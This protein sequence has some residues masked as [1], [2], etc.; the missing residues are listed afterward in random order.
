MSV[1]RSYG[2]IMP[3]QELAGWALAMK[4]MKEGAA[5]NIT[6]LVGGDHEEDMRKM[7]IIVEGGAGV[8][9]YEDW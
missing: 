4:E 1:G 9:Y 5:D 2:E 8:W 3:K 6:A 7:T